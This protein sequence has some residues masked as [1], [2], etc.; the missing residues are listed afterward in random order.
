MPVYAAETENY[1]ARVM[2][3]DCYLYRTPMESNDFSNVYFKLPRTYFVE[4]TEA[5]GDNFYKANYRNCSGYVKK[6]SVRAIVGTPK[7]P[8]YESHF[9]VY[10]EQS[11]I[12][13]SEPTSVSGSSSQIIYVPLYSRDLTFI[14]AVAGETFVEGRTNVWYYCKFSTDKDY[15]GYIYSEFC[16]EFEL[17]SIPPNK[18]NVTYTDIPVFTKPVEEKTSMPIESKTTAVVIA[19]LCVPALIFL[20]LVVKS[21][22]FS[23]KE[24]TSNKEVK[25]FKLP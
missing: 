14:G 25:D 3:E 5:V 9:R 6:D 11:R 22:K 19:V 13:R 21:S 1:Y 16:D 23:S 18:E 24:H 7:K 17:D 20:F 4:L 10:S 8:Y 15:Y 12:M 2:V